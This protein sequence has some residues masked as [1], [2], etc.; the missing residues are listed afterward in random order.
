MLQREHS[1]ILSTFIKL[2][3][4][5]KIF[6]LSIFGW[7]FY[8]GFTVIEFLDSFL[9]YNQ[10][11]RKNTG[12]MLMCQQFQGMFIK[13][14][15]H[16]WRN[17]VITIVQLV[18]PIIFTI[19]ALATEKAIPSVGDEPALALNS[20]PFTDFMVP[21]STGTVS[22]VNNLAMANS[23][24][25]QFGNADLVNRATHSTMDDYFL[26][27]KNEIGISTFNSKVIAAGD[28][29]YGTPTEVMAHF[30]DQPYHGIAISLHYTM[31]GM[32]RYFT[33]DSYNIYTTNH[34][35]PKRLNDNSRRIFFSTSGTGFTVAISV[36]FGMAFMSTSF[37]IFLIKER[38]V[39]A[40]HL[41][42]V[43]GVGPGAFWLSTF[44]W[45]MI[46]YLVPVLC[47]L[48]VFAAFQTSAYVDDGRLG[49]VFLI[50]M[51]YGWAVLPFVYLLSYLFKVPA[52]G[53]VVVSMINLGTGKI[54]SLCM[55][56][57]FS[58]FF[59]IC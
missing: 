56:G 19:M 33:G 31:N 16:T 24:K 10:N 27:K 17:K 29:E 30:N 15:I 12:L 25:N 9:G 53:M 37:I 46:N 14:L 23:F 2:P 32:L 54:W 45:D 38:S 59:V 48:V 8:T 36:L 4:V 52:T 57:N 35:F 3:V 28:F 41:Q 18:L 11:I 1:A 50:F 55:L 47:I 39:G 51:V 49:I 58:G 44:L 6:V 20:Q 21:Y 42:V 13:K 43:S 34:P 40:K 26:S 22:N 5:I 7:Q